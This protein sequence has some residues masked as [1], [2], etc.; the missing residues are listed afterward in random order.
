MCGICGATSDHDRVAVTAMN[1]ALTH[2]GPDDE[3]T[4]VDEANGIALGAR[5]L[6]IVDVA[7]GHQPAANEDGSVHVVFNGE[8]YNHPDLQRTLLGRGHVLASRCD[9]ELLPHLY[10][11]Y[12][13]EFVHALEGM[14]AFA[15]WD[16]SRR[17][18]LLGRDRFG[19]KPLFYAEANGGLAFASELT[20]LGR[21][22]ARQ[23]ELDPASLDEFFVFGYVPGPRTIIKGIRQL[24]PGHILTWDLEARASSERCY[25]SPPHHDATGREPISELAAETGRL[26][27]RSISGRLLADVPLGIFLSGGVDS[28][29]IAAL[30]A[31]QT[32]TP[33]KSFTVGYDASG[34]D[35]RSEARLIAELIGT[36]HHELVLTGQ[37]AAVRVPELLGGLDQPLADQAIVPLHAVAEFARSEVTVAIGG[38]GADELFGGY[39]RYGWLR[40]APRA[41]PET[42]SRIPAKYLQSGPAPTSGRVRRALDLAIP[43]PLLERNLDWVSAN[44][45]SARSELYGPTLARSVDPTGVVSSLRA[46]FGDH[47]PRDDLGALMRL[48]Q[49]HWL[50]DDV[51][52]KADRAGMAVS[53]EV[54]T[55]YLH[56]ELA[57]FAASVPAATHVHRGGKRLLRV[58]LSQLVPAAPQRRKVPFLPPASSWL[59]GPLAPVMRRQIEGGA[60]YEEE[61]FSRSVAARMLDEH[62]TGIADRTHLL[63]PLLAAGLWLDRLRGIGS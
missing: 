25:W 24:P 52:V 50:P 23:P 46:V 63:W 1:A 43:R 16:S 32:S 8:I 35:E 28:T 5:R 49:L 37:D 10:E 30:A 62:V 34:Y 38:E 14:F 29:V 39:P 55:P 36:D 51:L 41:W 22:L 19:E 56:R 44:R 9:T 47:R 53:L 26:L 31:R 45:R 57:E 27:E 3:G 11:D 60:V 48:D 15:L 4:Y 7:G 21:G 2:R 20:A 54:R 59:Q 33:I 61:W 12:G 42:L 17:R 18:L 58:L 13:D 6:S 40:H